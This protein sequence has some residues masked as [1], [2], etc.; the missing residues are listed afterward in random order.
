[1]GVGIVA[2]SNDAALILSEGPDD[3]RRRRRARLREFS[4]RDGMGL[5]DHDAGCRPNHQ[6]QKLMHDVFAVHQLY[7]LEGRKPPS[8]THFSHSV[9]FL[10]VLQ[11]A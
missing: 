5:V 9:C 3:S 11:I 10:T 7:P 8:S 4:W 6:R 1:M 2:D